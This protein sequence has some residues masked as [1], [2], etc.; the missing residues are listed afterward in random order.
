MREIDKQKKKK[1]IHGDKC[2]TGEEKQ[3]Q[4]KDEQEEGIK[5]NT[6]LLEGQEKFIYKIYFYMYFN[7]CLVYLLIYLFIITQG[8]CFH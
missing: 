5:K 6:I 4:R 3:T 2:K 8:Y 1:K 7:L